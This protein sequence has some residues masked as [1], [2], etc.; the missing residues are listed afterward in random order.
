M[1]LDIHITTKNNEIIHV[2]MSEILHSSIFSSSTRWSS[3]KNLRKIKDYYKTNCLLKDK[4]AISFIHELTEMENR[5]TD[6]KDELH[7][8][9]EKVK[10][11]QVSF[12]RVSGD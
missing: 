4:N 3:S 7:K 10:N 6:G 1:G 9:I 8:I 5:I 11:I 2:V 12:I